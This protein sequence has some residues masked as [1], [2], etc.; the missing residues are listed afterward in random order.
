MA[1]L[2][3]GGYVET[4]FQIPTCSLV[5]TGYQRPGRG[6]NVRADDPPDGAIDRHVTEPR[7]HAGFTVADRSRTQGFL[8]NHPA[9]L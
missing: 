9:V 3:E 2:L 4:C 1:I 7:C 6:V 8:D 5:R